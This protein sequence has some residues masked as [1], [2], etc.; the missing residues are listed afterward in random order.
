MFTKAQL[1]ER[2]NYIGGSDVAAIL[3]ISKFKSA[4]QLYLEKIADPENIEVFPQTVDQEWGSRKEPIVL[5]KFY[6]NHKDDLFIN[7]EPTYLDDLRLY[8]NDVINPW[9]N[10]YHPD[11]NFLRANIDGC[12]INYDTGQLEF[13]IEAKTVHHS[14]SHEWGEPGTGEIP[15]IYKAQCAHYCMVYNVN[16]V[17]VPVLIGTNDYREYV[18]ERNHE[19]EEYILAAEIYFWTNHVRARV[20]PEPRTLEDIKEFHRIA[21]KGS[22]IIANSQDK[23]KLQMLAAL[24]QLRKDCEQK[25]D[26]LKKEIMKV[27]GDNEILED[28]DGIT[29]ITWKNVSPRQ[30]LDYKKLKEEMP[31]VYENYCYDSKPNR[32]FL[33]KELMS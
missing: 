17:Y 1:I 8:T 10:N 16:K 11:Y 15:D 23:S 30:V 28:E 3:G 24:R 18:Y 6:D 4:Y 29:L 22:K 26:N 12:Y 13:I 32:M 2:Q 9:E 20:A 31:D 27:M 19:T 14:K 7:F 21:N 25:E 33:I 5:R